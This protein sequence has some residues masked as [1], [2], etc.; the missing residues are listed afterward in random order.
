MVV[1]AYAKYQESQQ[2]AAQADQQAKIRDLQAGDAR[3]LGQAAQGI[4]RIQ[5]GQEKANQ[6]LAYA[7]AGV[8]VSVGTPL[9]VKAQTA[10]FGELEAANVE[11][12]SIRRA[13]GFATEARTLRSEASSM[14]QSANVQLASSFI[15]AAGQGY[16]GYSEYKAGLNV[17]PKAQLASTNPKT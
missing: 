17:K 10:M 12:D 13:W 11:N 6:E 15:S 16:A 8:D 2:A 14:R 5:T 3:L 9:D 7:S 1:S 4:T